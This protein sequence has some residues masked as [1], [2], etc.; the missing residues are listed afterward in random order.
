MPAFDLDGKT[1][2][3]EAENDFGAPLENHS[4]GRSAYY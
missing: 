1:G 4:D 3:G 2:A